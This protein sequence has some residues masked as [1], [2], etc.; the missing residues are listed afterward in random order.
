MALLIIIFL[1]SIAAFIFLSRSTGVRGSIIQSYLLVFGTTVLITEVLSLFNKVTYQSVVFAWVVLDGLAIFLVLHAIKNISLNDQIIRLRDR[2]SK[3]LNL[4]WIN[5]LILFCIG[6]ILLITFIIAVS[7]PPNTFDSMTYH[8]SRVSN[9]IQHKSVRFYPTGNERQ[10]YSMPLAEYMILHIQILSKSDLYANLAQWSGLVVVLFV[11]TDIAR[12]LNVSQT[13]QLVSALFATTLPAAIL[14]STSTQNDLLAGVFCLI[15]TYYLILIIRDFSWQS[16]CLAGLGMGLALFTKG[17]SYVYCASLGILIGGVSLLMKNDIDRLRLVKGFVILV[18]IALLINSGI[19]IRNIA[20]YSHPLSTENDRVTNN[21]ISPSVLYANLV[22]NG[23]MHLAVPVPDINEALTSF[24]LDHLGD[25]ASDPDSTYLNMKFKVQFLINEDEAGNLL[26][27]ILFPFLM[28]IVLRRG[29]LKDK[30][31][32]Q[33]L[34]GIIICVLLYSLLFKWQPWGNRLQL[35]I[36]LVGAPL[37]GYGFDKIRP[38]RTLLLIFIIGFFLYSSPYLTLNTTRPLVPVFRK[39]SPFRANYVRKFFSNRPT[40][41]K[42]YSEIIAPFYK[43][44]SVL[45]ADREYQYFAGNSSRLEDYQSVMAVVN[46]L[47]MEEIGLYLTRNG[48]EYPIWVLANKHA[49]LNSPIFEHIGMDNKSLEF[50]GDGDELPR[51]VITNK[52]VENG[53]LVNNNYSIVVDTPSIDLV[54]R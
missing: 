46:Q 11:V 12:V 35:P 27:F 49:S 28:I 1:I 16:V 40:L 13:G 14:Q 20:L 7:A 9:W 23:A 39:N 26:H 32:F 6:F 50:L 45:R 29:I 25:K 34:G 4:S 24:L 41:Y 38:S 54:E 30:M 18:I 5:K 33:Y 48:W 47:E 8:M 31:V 17:T 37:I 15:F 51:Y 10:N 19:Y 21:R 42:E 3:W 52:Y 2:V 36:F 22:R 53:Y 44:V 43:D